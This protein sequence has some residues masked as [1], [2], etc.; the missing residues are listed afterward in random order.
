[1]GDGAVGIGEPDRAFGQHAAGFAEI[2]DLIGLQHL[3]FVIDLG[4][5]LGRDG[6]GL[7]VIDDAIGLHDHRRLLVAAVGCGKPLI[8]RMVGLLRPGRRAKAGQGA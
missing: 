5:A 3:A 2:D 6:M 7:V 4:V 1:M 8:E